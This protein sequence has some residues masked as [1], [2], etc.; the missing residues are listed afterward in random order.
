MLCWTIENSSGVLI[1]VR[2]IL[3]IKILLDMLEYDVCTRIVGF[4]Y[5]TSDTSSCIHEKIYIPRVTLLR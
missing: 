3:D 4:E 2:A 1:S 5:D